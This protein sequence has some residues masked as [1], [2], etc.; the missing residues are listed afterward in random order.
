MRQAHSNPRLKVTPTWREFHST[1][2]PLTRDWPTP[3]PYLPSSPFTGLL[4]LYSVEPLPLADSG[5]PP[6]DLVLFGI[7]QSIRGGLEA[8]PDK[9]AFAG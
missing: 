6:P 5:N 9:E 3:F 7:D 8:A 2:S 4:D 1:P